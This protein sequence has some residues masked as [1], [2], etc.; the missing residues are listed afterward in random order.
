MPD[1]VV[2]YVG[3]GGV[4]Q[5][6]FRVLV[7]MRKN[8]MPVQVTETRGK[9]HMLR[10]R[11]RLVS[12]EQHLMLQQCLLYPQMLVS[13]QRQG[14]IQTFNLAPIVGL[15]GEALGSCLLSDELV[16]NESRVVRRHLF[17][18]PLFLKKIDCFTGLLGG[19]AS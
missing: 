5:Q 12:E 1:G 19:A 15:G 9:R 11:Y 4:N 3:D 17:D 14:C 10:G 7:H 8:R 6:Q 13:A 18:F 16:A 2:T